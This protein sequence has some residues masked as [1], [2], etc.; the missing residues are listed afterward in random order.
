MRLSTKTVWTLYGLFVHG[1]KAH[2]EIVTTNFSIPCDI[3]IC[4]MIPAA[5]ILELI[6][7]LQLWCYQ[8]MVYH[9]FLFNMLDQSLLISDVSL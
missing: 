3:A 7:K 2:N 1:Y 8:L 6:L 4:V 5:V 9:I